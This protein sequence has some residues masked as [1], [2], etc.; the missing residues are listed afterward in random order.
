MDWSGGAPLYESPNSLAF[1]SCWLYSACPIN[2]LCM[3]IEDTSLTVQ[4]L[5]NR[6]PLPP[7]HSSRI[8]VNASQEETSY[9]I[10]HHDRVG[11]RRERHRHA[12]LVPLSRF[13]LMTCSNAQ[14]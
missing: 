11:V 6:Y 7:W 2:S 1:T 5:G 9:Y 10:V 12:V 14:F 8:N 3:L 13:E 4:C